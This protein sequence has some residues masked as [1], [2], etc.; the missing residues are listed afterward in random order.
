M[1]LWQH[2]MH[3]RTKSKPNNTLKRLPSLNQLKSQK[4]ERQKNLNRIDDHE[5]F[6]KYFT[7]L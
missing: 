1:K 2:L 7:Y 3:R 4:K 5:I 6:Q